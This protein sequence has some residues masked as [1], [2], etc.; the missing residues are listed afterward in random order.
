MDVLSQ[1]AVKLMLLGDA[2]LEDVEPGELP[3]EILLR[4]IVDGS[5]PA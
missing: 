2:G 4:E 3:N 5:G 1:I